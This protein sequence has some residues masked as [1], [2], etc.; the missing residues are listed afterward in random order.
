M[1]YSLVLTEGEGVGCVVC[2][3]FWFS[4]RKDRRDGCYRFGVVFLSTV[5]QK[6]KTLFEPGVASGRHLGRKTQLVRL[7]GQVKKITLLLFFEVIKN[8]FHQ[9]VDEII[10]F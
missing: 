1:K 6:W 2:L 5:R 9:L 7:Y 3:G 10:S 4:W 8:I